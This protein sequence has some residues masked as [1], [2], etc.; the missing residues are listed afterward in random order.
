MSTNERFA[1]NRFTHVEAALLFVVA[2]IAGN[3]IL[4]IVNFY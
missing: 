2:V 4:S 1:G 3:L